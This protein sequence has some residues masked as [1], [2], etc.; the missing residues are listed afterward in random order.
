MFL[1]TIGACVQLSYFILIVES[2]ILY[3]S[4]F[5]IGSIG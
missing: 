1:F 4:Q 2:F 3:A 5:L